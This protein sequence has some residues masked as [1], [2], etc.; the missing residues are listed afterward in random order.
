VLENYQVTPRDTPATLFERVEPQSFT[1]ATDPA[2]TGSSVAL[3]GEEVTL[4]AHDTPTGHLEIEA[5]DGAVVV[6][7]QTPSDATID[8]VSPRV[9][10]VETSM[11]TTAHVVLAAG[12][13]EFLVEGDTIVANLGANAAVHT[14][15]QPGAAVPAQANFEDRVR[16]LAKGNLGAE[17]AVTAVDAGSAVDRI[18]T[19]VQ[20]ASTD[21]G[22]GSLTVSASSQNSDPRAVAPHLDRA[23]AGL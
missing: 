5:G 7:L 1:P 3:S 21:V 18:E 15:V 14:A 4:E 19:G 11:G 17:V 20:A 22:V 13:G 9:L 16:A 10:E 8:R 23:M 2:E 12:N 6:E